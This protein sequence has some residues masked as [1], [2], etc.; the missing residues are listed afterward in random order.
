MSL[1]E[2]FPFRLTFGLFW[3]VNMVVRIYFQSKARGTETAY[4]TH[5]NRARL[6]FWIFGLS[7]LLM[8]FYFFTSWFDFAHIGLS[9]YI[10]WLC[11]GGLLAAYI[12]L[13]GWTHA[14]LGKNWSPLLEMHK[15]HVL[16]ISG[17]YRFIRHPMYAAFILSG[18]GFLTFS[19]NWLIGG[20]YLVIAIIMYLDR[21]QPEEAMMEL[22]F[23]KQY[24]EYARHTGRIVPKLFR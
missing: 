7:Y 10:R 2:E 11:G 8:A 18:A 4:A 19:A 9:P 24:V 3:L 1:E 15:D 20:L 13:F 23:G 5:T 6:F 12:L 16:I 22:Y 21:V 14:V 17:P